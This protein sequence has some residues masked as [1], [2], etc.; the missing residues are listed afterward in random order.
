MSKQINTLLE[1][2]NK[3]A[4]FAILNVLSFSALILKLAVNDNA[5][6]ICLAIA[7]IAIIVS[8]EK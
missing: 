3:F 8:E 4:Q 6:V 1:T 7:I 2:K 5:V